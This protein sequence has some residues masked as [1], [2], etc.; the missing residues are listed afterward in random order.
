MF[1]KECL[2]PLRIQKYE[3]LDP[4]L[5]PNH[6]IRPTL[7]TEY[8][9]WMAG[10]KGEK[11]LDFY[12]SMLPEEKYLIFHNIRLLLGRYFFQIDILLLCT[13]FGLVLEVKNRKGEY[14]FQKY[15]NQTTLKNERIRN[16]I[17]QKPLTFQP[18]TIIFF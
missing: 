3:A 4:R 16:P 8:N 2:L 18:L 14:F 10:Y 7:L 13:A 9:N 12:L 1:A 5:I 17:I 6:P 11:S 15:L